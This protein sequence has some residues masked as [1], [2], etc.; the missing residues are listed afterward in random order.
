LALA[1][2]LVSA[3]ETLRFRVYLDKDPIG[4]HSFQISPG[5]SGEQV[6]QVLS[7]A[8]FDV[9]I[10]F[11]NA[12]R[13]RH[14]SREL[15]RD[16]C[17]DRIRSNTDDNGKSFRVEGERRADALS[18]EV[19]GDAQRLAGCVGSFA[20]WNPKLLSQP[21][22]LNPQTGELVNA[23]LEPA[24]SERR[25]HQ[26][27]EVMARRYRLNADRLAIS[28]WYADD[29]AWIGLESDAGKGRTLRYERI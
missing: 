14:E 5:P 7:R 3:S 10:L 4:E 23:R 9:D 12:Y 15:W 18:L 25:V 27:R 2:S 20:Y 11:F 28:L 1:G 26:G 17:L 6:E 29:G 21:R 8:S 16:G 24:G 13:Y 19:N 22:L